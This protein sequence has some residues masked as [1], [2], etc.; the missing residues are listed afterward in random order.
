MVGLFPYDGVDEGYHS[1]SHHGRDETKLTQVAIVEEAIVSQWSD[2]LQSL[3]EFDDA[4]GSLLDDTTS[5]LTSNLG[6]ASN[7][8]N[9]NMPV[10]IGGGPFRHAGHLAF[11][12]KNNYPLAN[13]Y[14]SMLQKCGL[15]ID[16]FASSTGTMNALS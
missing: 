3:P 2:M 8:S 1:L 10:M 12:Q 15:E 14:V 7:H 16:Q 5:M 11:S 9:Q 13:F 4:H 6:N